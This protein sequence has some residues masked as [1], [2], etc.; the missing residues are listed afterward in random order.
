MK[1]KNC[2]QQALQQIGKVGNSTCANKTSGYT[3]PT[4]KR[5]KGLKVK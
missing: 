2:N 3:D 4:T 5:F 1:N